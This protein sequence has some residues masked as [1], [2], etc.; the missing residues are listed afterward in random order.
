M[1]QVQSNAGYFVHESSCVD[2]GATIGRETKIW[3]FSHVMGGSR[4]GERCVLGQNVFVAANVTIG[5]GVRIQNN[6]S[7]YE[8]VELED[9]VFCGPSVVF[10]NVRTPRSAWPRKDYAVTKIKRG[11]TLGANC[12]IVCGATIG[13]FALIGAGSVVTKDVP[14][15]AVVYGNPARLRGYACQCGV[16]LIFSQQ[17]AGCPECRRGYVLDGT[18]IARVPQ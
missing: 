12:T 17:R 1:I 3:H 15:H 2:E 14:P 8:G 11:A 16:P 4:I 6:V 13:E 9:D 10:T 18:G 7:I 5:N